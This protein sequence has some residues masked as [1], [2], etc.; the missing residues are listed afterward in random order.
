MANISTV[1]A[2]APGEARRAPVLLGELGALVVGELAVGHVG[3]R[4]GADVVSVSSGELVEVG[5]RARNVSGLGPGSRLEEDADVERERGV[6]REGGG[7][8]DLGK[9][10]LD[11]RVKTV[12]ERFDEEELLVGGLEAV[13]RDGVVDVVLDGGGALG[14]HLVLVEEALVGHDVD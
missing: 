3:E 9:A 7:V 10:R 5:G 1:G 13:H 11:L 14:L 4:I 12:G 8:I 6:R 2:N